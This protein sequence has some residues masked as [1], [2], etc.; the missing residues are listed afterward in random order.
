MNLKKIFTLL[1]PQP[2]VAGLQIT[3]LALRF[4]LAKENGSIF[5]SLKLPG[6]IIEEG[7]IKNKEDFKSALIRLHSQITPQSNKKIYVV[8]NISENNVYSQVFNLPLVALENLEE[9]VKLNL[10]MISPID[11]ASVYSDWQKVGENSIDGG[12]LEILGAFINVKIVDEFIECLGQANFVA[13]AVEFSSL[14][15]SRLASALSNLVQPFLLLHLT[16]DGLDFALIKN[17]NLYFNHFVPWPSLDGRQI[18]LSVVKEILVRETKNLLNFASSRWP[19][20]QINTLVLATPTL[21]EK[22]SQII[23]ENFSLAV[24]K[25][26]LPSKLKSPTDKWSLEDN[27]FS[28]LTSDWFIS[29]GSAL[30]GLIPRSKDIIISLASTGTE[31][32]FR[33]ET[34]INFI[35]LWRNIVLA[36]L[37]F[38]L[39]AFFGIDGFLI[40]TSNSLNNQISNLADLTKNSEINSFQQVAQ[41][42]N[43]K[44]NL[45]LDA[46]NQTFGWSPFFEKIKNLAANDI[47]IQRILIQSPTSVILFDGQAADNEAIINFK[48]ELQNDP[49]FQEVNFSVSSVSPAA[50]GKLNFSMTF[51]LKP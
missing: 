21:E 33:Q 49:E 26:I 39:I 32:E 44:V 4:V 46:K 41:N 45:A 5:T 29:L 18:S 16:V 24:Q 14:A 1:N 50:D 3:D 42:F 23:T 9:A 7:K 15:I 47:I 38:I 25:M 11:F 22:L 48:N 10:Q 19:D 20:T 43:A 27:Q 28:S 17:Y 12:Q 31:E 8:V 35:K 30:R 40:R 36:S 34:I 6:G 2:L 37:F 13:A 51:K